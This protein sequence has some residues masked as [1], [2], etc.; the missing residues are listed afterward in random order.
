MVLLDMKRLRDCQKKEILQKF[1]KVQLNNQMTFLM[2]RIVSIAVALNILSQEEVSTYNNC[3]QLFL[4]FNR[5]HDGSSKHKQSDTLASEGKITKAAARK[6]KKKSRNAKF[7]RPETFVEHSKP[8]LN[9]QSNLKNMGPIQDLGTINESMSSNQSSLNRSLKLQQR[10][11]RKQ[12]RNPLG[13][14]VKQPK[15]YN[16]IHE[17][18]T[19]T[20]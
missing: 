17:L 14:P 6:A 13:L 15:P 11:E 7:V 2:M 8:L 3:K 20:K 10:K 1:L 4:I 19:F 18:R 5:A 9:P 16:P 12:A